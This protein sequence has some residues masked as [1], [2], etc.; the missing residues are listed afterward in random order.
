MQTKGGH[1]VQSGRQ[2]PKIRFG[3]VVKKYE[4]L[5][6][7]YR[8]LELFFSYLPSYLSNGF[9]MFCNANSTRQRRAQ[10]SGRLLELAREASNEMQ[11]S[12]ALR[13]QNKVGDKVRSGR[14]K[15]QDVENSLP[16]IAPK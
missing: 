5:K 14:T 12:A 13:D 15:F 6:S 2:K 11:A 10:H 1:E 8:S 4:L 3:E 16:G 9:S 7:T